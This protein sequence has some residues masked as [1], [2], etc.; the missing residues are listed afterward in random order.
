MT[1]QFLPP[2]IMTE[3]RKCMRRCH[4][5]ALRLLRRVDLNH[6]WQARDRDNPHVCEWKS[7]AWEDTEYSVKSKQI[8]AF[9]PFEMLRSSALPSSAK[10]GQSLNLLYA[11]VLNV[12]GRGHYIWLPCLII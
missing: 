6:L 11:A 8:D 1:G 3:Q 12:G 2:S 9:P 5:R 10:A 7:K 4:G